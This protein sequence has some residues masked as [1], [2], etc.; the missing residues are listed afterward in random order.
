MDFKE[1]GNRVGHALTSV[2]GVAGMALGGTL[3]NSAFNLYRENT[4]YRRAKHDMEK[5]GINPLYGMSPASSSQGLDLGINSALAVKQMEA[6][7]DAQN[8]QANLARAQALREIG[9]MG[10]DLNLMGY[11]AGFHKKGMPWFG[12]NT[13]PYGRHP[14]GMNSAKAKASEPEKKSDAAQ[15]GD[16]PSG[17]RKWLSKYSWSKKG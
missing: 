9:T 3:I 13:L 11:S 7:I 10:I 5:A 14:L 16:Q 12:D 17:W 8:E 6:Q 4:A 15:N 2:P 1:L